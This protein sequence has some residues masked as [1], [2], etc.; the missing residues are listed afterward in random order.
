MADGGPNHNP[1]DFSLVPFANNDNDNDH[2]NPENLTPNYRRA[3]FVGNDVNGNGSSSSSNGGGN[4]NVGFLPLRGGGPS[5]TPNP[6]SIVPSGSTYTYQTNP[7]PENLT[8]NYCRII[9]ESKFIDYVHYDNREWYSR[10]ITYNYSYIERDYPF[11]SFNFVKLKEMY[12]FISWVKFCN[13][14]FCTWQVSPLGNPTLEWGDYDIISS[15]GEGIT[16]FS[17]SE[18]THALNACTFVGEKEIYLNLIQL[19]MFRLELLYNIM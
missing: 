3:I 17:G 10:L 1:N 16:I 15:F 4:G 5:Y 12:P 19:N 18:F 8:P 6:F 2:T 11:L 7:E 14:Y 13:L 9:F